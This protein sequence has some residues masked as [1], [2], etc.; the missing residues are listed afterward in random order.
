MTGM[1]FANLICPRCGNGKYMRY[2]PSEL[3]SE[4]DVKCIN[5]NT[6]WRMSDFEKPVKRRTNYESI[7]K[8]NP[9][10]F[11]EWID[12]QFGS[13]DWCDKDRLVGGACKGIECV[14]C[15]VEWLSK[16]EEDG[17]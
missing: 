1:E 11:A 2:L 16:E 12:N 15:I 6:Y 3:Q 8:K 10:E 4:F 17:K 5:C 7:M 13:L 14:E 9:E